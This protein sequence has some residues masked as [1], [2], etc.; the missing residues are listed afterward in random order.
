M[1]FVKIGRKEGRTFLTGLN[2]ITRALSTVKPYDTLKCSK[3]RLSEVFL[4]TRR[5]FFF[6]LKEPINS[7]EFLDP[8][9]SPLD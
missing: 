6:W 7:E 2:K 5:T 8:T 9:Y 4:R 3:E 1:S